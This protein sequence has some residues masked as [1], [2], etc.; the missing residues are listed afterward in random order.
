MP[1]LHKQQVSVI[2][3]AEAGRRMLAT[4]GAGASERSMF[5]KTDGVWCRGRADWLDDAGKFDVDVKTCDSA[6]PY[7]FVRRNVYANC[8][9]V[10]A[11]LRSLGHEA[12]TG[13]P[14]EM[15]WLLVEIAAPYATSFVGV[16]PAMLDLATRKV[17]YAAKIWRKCLDDNAWPGY[18]SIIHW[19][20][21]QAFAE[22]E[23]E[24]RSGEFFK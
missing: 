6:E 17:S 1:L 19:A 12:I 14:R 7:A 5:W 16:G 20:D 18:P 22:M 9:D 13:K 2:K 24:M 11:G 23:F 3:A 8:L 10:Q 15:V 4:L 21:P